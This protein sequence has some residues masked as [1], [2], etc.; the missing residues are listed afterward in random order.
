MKSTPNLLEHNVK[1]LLEDE[2]TKFNNSNTEYSNNTEDTTVEPEV[3]TATIV[4]SSDT[5]ENIIRLIEALAE[6]AAV[7]GDLI[8]DPKVFTLALTLVLTAKCESNNF[9]VVAPTQA[10]KINNERVAAPTQGNFVRTTYVDDQETVV[11]QNL[12][13][14][15]GLHF[16][17]AVSNGTSL[18]LNNTDLPVYLSGE[19]N[20]AASTQNKLQRIF[21]QENG[22]IDRCIDSISINCVPSAVLVDRANFHSDILCANGTTEPFSGHGYVCSQ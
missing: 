4:E 8:K 5:F 7:L 17:L 10:E 11:N 19:G 22:V 1:G 12:I 2:N 3:V 14:V 13:V 18:K 16:Y 9:E 21:T 15:N 20:V 6:L